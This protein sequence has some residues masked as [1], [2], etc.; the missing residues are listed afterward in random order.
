M[1][2]DTEYLKINRSPLKYIP[3]IVMA[4]LSINVLSLALPLTMKQIYSNIIVN[5]S[6]RTFILLI[7]GCVV[8]LA[9]EALLRKIKDSSSKWIASEYE[10]KLSTYLIGKVLNSLE[11]DSEEV[12]YNANLEK[13][14]SISRVTTFYSTG[15][16]QLFIDLPFMLI[17][18]YLIFIIGGYLVL[19]PIFLSLIYMVIMIINS[20]LYFKNREIQ[21]EK[22]NKLISQ[23]SETIEKIHLVKAAGLEESQIAKF[24][25][26]L[27]ESTDIEFRV[28]K[29]QVIPET[30]SSKFSQLTLFSILV[31]GS[32]LM[33][34]GSISFGE[35]TACSL[36]GGRA[37]SPVQSL[38]NLYLQHK[39][40]KLLRGRLDNIAYRTDRYSH[41]IPLFPEDINGTIEIIDLKYNNIQ[42][43]LM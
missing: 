19:V 17:F 41:D 30:I 25:K 34:N 40:V 1:K 7:V 16:I 11:G 10:N 9:L 33:I 3:I 35:I 20:E 36:L 27:K 23:L 6:V 5:E 15:F 24:K 2:K 14:N 32:Y 13:F 22:N 4:S 37:I 28:N 31:A 29:F 21:I 18:L 26:I 38:M 12:D 8:A 39:D 43:N 42:N